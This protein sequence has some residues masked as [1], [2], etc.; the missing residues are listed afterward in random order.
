MQHAEIVLSRAVSSD[1]ARELAARVRPYL[2]P[3]VALL[4]ALLVLVKGLPAVYDSYASGRGTFGDLSYL[5][6]A[7]E[8]AT[9]SESKTLYGPGP[10]VDQTTYKQIHGHEY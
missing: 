4:F 1:D 9:S 7:S 3:A 8:L 10:V 5:L 2:S 6:D